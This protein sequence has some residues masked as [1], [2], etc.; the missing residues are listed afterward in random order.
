M[1]IIDLKRA[2]ISS[3]VALILTFILFIFSS[4]LTAISLIPDSAIRTVVIIISCISAFIGGYLTSRNVYEYGL[5]NGLATGILYFL[6]MYVL[7]VIMS[8]T[9]A[10]NGELFKGLLFILIAS[11]AGGVVGINSKAQRRRRKNS[12]YSR[13]YR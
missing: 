8:F 11:A 10:F 13:R 5:F 2:I 3:V 9:F 6:M 1:G 4:L 12:A 7:S